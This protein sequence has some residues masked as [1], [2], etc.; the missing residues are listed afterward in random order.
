MGLSI[1]KKIRYNNPNESRTYAQGIAHRKGRKGISMEDLMVLDLQRF[2]EDGAEPAAES[3]P[4]AA[5]AQTDSGAAANPEAG[6]E[7]ARPAFADLIA[8]EY[9]QDYE[10]A[11][12]QRGRQALDRRFRE[13]Q[14][15][16]EQLAKYQDVMRILG[17]KYKMDAADVD[18][19]TERVKNDDSMYAAY[20]S[21]NGIP[22]QMAKE[23]VQLMI[24]NQIAKENQQRTVEQQMLAQ[25]ISRLEQEAEELKKVFPDFDLWKEIRENE[26]FKRM[27]SPGGG[28]SVQDAYYAIHGEEIQRQSMQ[29]AAQQAIRNV[30]ASVQAGASR[31]AEN[32]L[33]SGQGA[34]MAVDVA[35]MTREQREDIRKRVH[36]GEAVTF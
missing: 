35:H 1:L 8:G 20:A 6:S 16:R 7:Q 26:R 27:T 23:H 10:A 2:A 5:E 9:R 30:A 24:S 32:G 19:I 17:Q 31:P 33:K 25:H 3:A 18:G 29:Y 21:E 22:V 36:S 28:L 11:V 14:A 4:A 13:K 34:G 15:E 12:S